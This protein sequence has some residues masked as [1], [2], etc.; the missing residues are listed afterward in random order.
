MFIIRNPLKILL[1][2]LIIVFLASCTG[3]VKQMPEEERIYMPRDRERIRKT[4]AGRGILTEL[5][6]KS[7]RKSESKEYTGNANSFLWKA[8]LDVLSNFPLS[9]VDA[10][11]GL[12]ITDWY[13][14]E[15]KPQQRF[16]IT[17]LVL[18][19]KISSSAVKVKIYKQVIK[20]SR[21]VNQ[22]IETNKTLAIERKIIQK[23]VDLKAQ[24]S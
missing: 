17:V 12:I 9:S 4:K 10:R 11:S 8:S 22:K 1:V 7:T 15:S 6:K 14:S 16:K 5:F 18:S 21:W 20:S 19:D 24:N 3:N 13:S 23:A 2:L